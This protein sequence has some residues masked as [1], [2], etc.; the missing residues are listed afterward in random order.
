DIVSGRVRSRSQDGSLHDQGED[1]LD[2]ATIAQLAA[3]FGA[4]APPPPAEDPHI[5]KVRERRERAL[6]AVDPAFLARFEAKAGQ[7]EALLHLP[8]P[9]TLSIERMPLAKLD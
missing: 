4:P 6:E 2:A 7:A 3:W 5:R 9:M 8:E 1:E